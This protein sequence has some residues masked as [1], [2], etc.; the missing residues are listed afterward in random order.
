MTDKNDK[1]L[2]IDVGN[3]NIVSAVSEGGALQNKKRQE[4]SEDFSFDRDHAAQII[5][6]SVVPKLNDKITDY[7]EINFGLQPVFLHHQ[8][9]GLIV[10]IDKPEQAGA[11]RLANALALRDLYQEEGHAVIGIDFGTATSFDILNQDGHFIGGVLSPGINLSLKAFGD[12]A[13]QLPT[14]K[15]E[16]TD[17]VIGRNTVEAM[18]AGIYWGYVGLIE[19]T[20]KRIQSELNTEPGGTARVIATGGLAS[21]FES[22]IKFD[23]VDSDLTLKG[24]QQFAKISN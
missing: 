4:T 5:V 9:C 11:D 19:G 2:L 18:Q 8:N 21:L 12:A 6:A 3:T 17:K 24:L 10:D 1:T 16:E 14:L 13:A 22:Q 15:I 20:L 7:C 23:A